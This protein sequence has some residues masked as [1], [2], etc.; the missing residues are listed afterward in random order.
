MNININN[1]LGNIINKKNKNN[2]ICI[3]YK[4]KK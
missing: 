4:Y 2:I 3:P 1:D